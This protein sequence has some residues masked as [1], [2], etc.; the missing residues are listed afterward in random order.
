MATRTKTIL[1]FKYKGEIRPMLEKWAK[2]NAFN[3]R[4][5]TE[6]GVI[7]CQRGGG[8]MM[9]PI[10]LHIQQT[11]EEVHMEIWLKVDLL[12]EFA[13]LFT[14]PSQSGIETDIDGLYREREI[15]RFF[16]NKLLK[17]LNQPSI[18]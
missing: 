10:Y 4:D 6:E 17:E 12:T 13:N 9:C 1:N 14:V 7:E 5:A 18:K 16:I 2:E 8:S 11:N 3:I 15:A